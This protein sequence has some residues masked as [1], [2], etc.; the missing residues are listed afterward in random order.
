[1]I[2]CMI[3]DDEQHAIDLLS[4]YIQKI[5]A[6]ELLFTTTS[7]VEAFQ[8]L[9][10]HKPDL[11]FLDIQMPDL[12]GIQ[13]TRLVAGRSKIILTTAYSEHAVAAY[14]L[15]ILDYLLKPIHFERFLKAVQKMIS[16]QAVVSS[17]SSAADKE[18]AAG[19]EF[20]FVK[21]EARN[22][23]VKI[24]L[25]D[26]EYIEGMGNYVSVYTT[27]TR[28][29]TLLTIKELEE[30]LP[31]HR[32]IRVHNSYLVP[33]NKITGVEGNQ[34]HIGKHKLPI[35]DTYKTGLIKILSKHILGKK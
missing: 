3:I 5:P 29:I 18:D 20:I 22:K 23:I 1:M 13:F 6:L 14:E 21:T 34:L 25:R 7:P 19:E 28:V 26:I 24:L 17:G 8:Y 35:G 10:Q 30:K 11:I 32:F 31:A 27:S 2:R 4:G 33:V 9:H 12:D 16:L 15:D